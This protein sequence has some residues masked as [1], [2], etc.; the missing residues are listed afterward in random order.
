MCEPKIR[1]QFQVTSSKYFCDFIVKLHSQTTALL[2]N[3]K[4]N[5][6]STHCW[7][8]C[9]LILCETCSGMAVT[10]TILLNIQCV[11]SQ[12]LL[13]TVYPK[14]CKKW[15]LLGKKQQLWFKWTELRLNKHPFTFFHTK[16]NRCG[17]LT[18]VEYRGCIFVLLSTSLRC[19]YFT[20]LFFFNAIVC[21]SYIFHRLQKS[22]SIQWP[23]WVNS[24]RFMQWLCLVF[25]FDWVKGPKLRL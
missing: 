21:Y 20:K 14:S 18:V 22:L 17:S 5:S 7:T 24:I 6:S 1:K 23:H 13:N 4:A 9:V 3:K 8:L 2:Y 10:L 11:V 16:F 12:R 25:P 19:L 15:V